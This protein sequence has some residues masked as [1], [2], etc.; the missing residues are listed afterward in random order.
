MYYR[1]IKKLDGKSWVMHHWSVWKHPDH[2]TMKLLE[3][4][5]LMT[6][7]NVVGSDFCYGHLP[8]SIDHLVSMDYFTE[9]LTDYESTIMNIVV[10]VLIDFIT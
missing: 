1:S 4:L 6:N 3:F 9:N 5:A 8:E 10:A 2:F 7:K